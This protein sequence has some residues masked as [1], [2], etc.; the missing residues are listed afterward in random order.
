MCNYVIKEAEQFPRSRSGRHQVRYDVEAVA[1]SR[2][3]AFTKTFE[4]HFETCLGKAGEVE[5][6]SVN[7]KQKG[8]RNIRHAARLQNTMN[9]TC[10]YFGL[11]KMFENFDCNHAIETF[12]FERQVMGV[13]DNIDFV[14]R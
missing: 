3:L 4:Q 10:G 12:R 14:F 9:L 1:K 11:A 6:I 8:Y 13:S 7:M 2:Y 5:G